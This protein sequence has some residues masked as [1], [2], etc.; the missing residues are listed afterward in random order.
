MPF[1]L[2]QSADQQTMSGKFADFYVGTT[3]VL[4]CTDIEFGLRPGGD[5]V[6]CVGEQYPRNNPNM[7]VGSATLNRLSIYQNDL[8]DIMIANGYVGPTDFSTGVVDLRFLPMPVRVVYGD[9]IKSRTKTLLKVY[10]RELREQWSGIRLAT[11][12]W[13]MEYVQETDANS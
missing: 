13:T 12:T 8:S 10:I 1:V 9:G 5:M 2:P 7:T 6:Q 4:C 11:D 3:L